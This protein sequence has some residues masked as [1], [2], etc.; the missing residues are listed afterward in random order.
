MNTPATWHHVICA[1][2][3]GERIAPGRTSPIF[4]SAMRP[5]RVPFVHTSDREVPYGIVDA[6]DDEGKPGYYDKHVFANDAIADGEWVDEWYRPHY[7]SQ[8][9]W[10]TDEADDS[11]SEVVGEQSSPEYISDGSGSGEED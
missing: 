4:P 9:L 7:F 2:A 3:Y 1:V 11:D 8:G 10:I 5:L 6:K